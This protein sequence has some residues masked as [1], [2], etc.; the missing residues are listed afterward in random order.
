MHRTATAKI[1]STR[2]S[3]LLMSCKFLTLSL[4][5]G[6]RYTRL[7][8]HNE[9][10]APQITALAANTPIQKLNLTEAMITIHSPTKPA[11]AGKPQLAIENSKANA[12]NFGMVF[13][14]PP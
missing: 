1:P 7:Y 13:T 6:P 10:A 12:A 14:T 8:I 11:V 9:Y 2:N 5:T 4:V 3:R